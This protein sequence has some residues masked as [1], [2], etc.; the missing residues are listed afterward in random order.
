MLKWI[1][2][3]DIMNNT[4]RHSE[5]DSGP[6]TVPSMEEQVGRMLIVGFRGTDIHDGDPLSD[7][8]RSGRIGGVVLFDRDVQ[9]ADSDRNI[10]NP[11]QVRRLI[12]GLKSRSRHPMLVGVDQEGGRVSRLNP[13]HGFPETVSQQYLGERNDPSLTNRYGESSANLLSELGFNLN[14]SP[15][16]D[17]NIDP[18]GPAIGRFGRSFSAD[19]EITVRHARIVLESLRKHGILPVLKHFPGHGSAGGDTHLGLVDVSASWS[20]T[21]L[22]PFHRLIAEADPPMIM[23][24]HVFNRH[25]DPDFPATLSARIVTDLLRKKMGFKGVVVTD[26]LDMKAVSNRFGL[27][28]TVEL[29]VSAGVDILMF[30]NNLRYDPGIAE[31]VVGIILGLLDRGRIS[32]DRIRESIRRIDAMFRRFRSAPV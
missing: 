20:E 13:R 26:D 18:D 15:C 29:A 2:A 7:D 16:V 6:E 28:K 17:L 5:K 11:K 23:T 8:L 3:V 30:G 19:P 25:L 9:I 22:I 21:E 31:R 14:F 12:D 24:A 4:Q 27:E 10:S 1:K 32:P